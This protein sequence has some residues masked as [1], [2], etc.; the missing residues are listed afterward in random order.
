MDLTLSPSE[1]GFRDEVAT[2]LRANNPGPEPEG[3]LDEV[4]AFRREWQLKLHAAGWAGI[5]WPKEY[6][7]RGVTMIEQAMFVG[8]AAAEEAPIPANVL[9]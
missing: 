8:E 5:S 2:W 4:M 9:V 7:G 1:Q 6:G 3:S